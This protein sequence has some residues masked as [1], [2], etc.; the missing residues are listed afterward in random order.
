MG[1]VKFLNASCTFTASL[2]LKLEKKPE[3]NAS[4]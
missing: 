4:I 2:K 1:S 3:R